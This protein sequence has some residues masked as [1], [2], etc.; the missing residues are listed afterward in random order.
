MSRLRDRVALI[1]GGNT[2]IGRGVAL[3]FADEGAD[4]AIAYHG[5]PREAESAAREI[6]DKGRRALLVH[7]DVTD[8]IAVR[9]MVTDVLGGLG[10]IDIFVNNAGLQKPQA[11]TDMSLADW[12]G[13]MAVHLRGAFLC[14]RAVAP[15]MMLRGL[16][17]SSS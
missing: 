4:V 7:V 6:E 17:A 8:E 3:G 12:D 13:M 2:G 10:R 15:A 1:T 16:D 14:C 11:I 5:H 9:A